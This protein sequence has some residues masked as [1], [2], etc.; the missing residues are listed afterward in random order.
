MDGSRHESLPRPFPTFYS[1]LSSWTQLWWGI[2]KPAIHSPPIE[3]AANCLL[4]SFYFGVRA[5]EHEQPWFY[6]ARGLW[7]DAPVSALCVLHSA[8]YGKNT[9]NWTMISWTRPLVV[10]YSWFNVVCYS[11]WL[12][13]FTKASFIVRQLLTRHTFYVGSFWIILLLDLRLG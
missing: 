1:F 11:E 10:N 2:L 12:F 5:A 7:T 3:C 6:T 9:S 4:P 13:D 8:K